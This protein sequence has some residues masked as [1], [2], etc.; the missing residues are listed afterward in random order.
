M[1]GCKTQQKQV[2]EQLWL[3]RLNVDKVKNV[4]AAKVSLVDSSPVLP[5]ERLQPRI[6]IVKF[7]FLHL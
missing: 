6:V 7:P 1:P 3:Q 4:K 2:A 5:G